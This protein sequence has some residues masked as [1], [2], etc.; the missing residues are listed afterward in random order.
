MISWYWLTMR[1]SDRVDLGFVVD[2]VLLDNSK[3]F[4]AVCHS[5]LLSK[6]RDAGVN[7]ELLLG[8]VHSW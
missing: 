8:F 6:D 1:V 3:H 4:D 5:V 2:V 7:D